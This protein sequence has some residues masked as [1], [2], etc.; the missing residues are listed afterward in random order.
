[1]AHSTKNKSTSVEKKTVVSL[2]N[3][4]AESYQLKEVEN[5]RL[6]KK[7]GDLEICLNINKKMIDELMNN[8]GWDEK[9]RACLSLLQK[10]NKELQ[11]QM[12]SNEKQLSDTNL[13]VIIK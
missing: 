11:R 5:G 4:Y 9:S 2:I 8:S 7:I 10:E 13:K 3:S 12:K 6:L 1:M